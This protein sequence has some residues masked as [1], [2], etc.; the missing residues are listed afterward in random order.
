MNAHRMFMLEFGTELVPKSLSVLG[1]GSH[2]IETPIFGAL[3]ETDDGLI[4]LDTGISHEALHDPPA[5]T[6]IY[7]AGMHPYGPT[8]NPLEVALD[9]IGF[10]VGDIALAAVSHLHL[11]HTGGIPLLA[12]AGVPIV[13]QNREI[14][15]GLERAD[16][17]SELEVAFY[18]S[19]YTDHSIDWRKV[20][21]DEQIAPG[22]FTF[23]TPGHTPGHMSYRVDLP[24]TGTWILAADAA[25]LGENLLER[26][27]CGSVSEPSDARRARA[28]IHRLV[29]EGE[30]LDAR[31]IPGHDPVFWK[32]VWHPP[33]GHR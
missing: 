1:A 28:S 15:Y 25:D 3:V 10:K 17:G 19:D 5:L 6:T 16:D 13:I 32:A 14:D 20:D 22:V 24:E 4:L 2:V 29:E 9:T 18:R 30:R 23:A 27:P 8:G 21:G 7:G 33:G 31:L 26:T 11:D 12:K